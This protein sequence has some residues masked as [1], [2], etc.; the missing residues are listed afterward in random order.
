MTLRMKLETRDEE[1][2]EVVT[3]VYFEQVK[4]DKDGTHK[5]YKVIAFGPGIVNGKAVEETVTLQGEAE[6][7]VE[8]F[9]RK[10]FEDMGYKLLR[11]EEDDE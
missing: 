4:P 3:T 8:P 6:P 10:R 5:R 9:D 2:V 7:F 11:V 1:G